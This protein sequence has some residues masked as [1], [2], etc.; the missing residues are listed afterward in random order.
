MLCCIGAL[1]K[2]AKQQFIHPQL[3]KHLSPISEPKQI[4]IIHT[5]RRPNKFVKMVDWPPQEI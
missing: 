5:N 2:K 4:N 3:M 1:I